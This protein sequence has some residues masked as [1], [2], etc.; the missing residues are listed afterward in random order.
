VSSSDP[1]LQLICAALVLLAPMGVSLVAPNAG[2]RFRRAAVTAGAFGAGAS[3]ATS[4]LLGTPTDTATRILDAAMASS[5][6]V[7]VALIAMQRLGVAGG[8]VFAVGYGL[9]IGPAITNA[10]LG[11][12]PALLLT[13]FGA[14]DYAGVLATHVAPAAALLLVALMPT[15]AGETLPATVSPSVRR[16]LLGALFVGVG[17]L[18]WLIGLEGAID[19]VTGRIAVN[20]AVG[21]LIAV[22]AWVV[23]ERV[24][25]ARFT[26]AGMVAGAIAGWAAVG[27]GAPF[28]APVALVAVAFLGGLAAGA[29][30]GEHRGTQGRAVGART[31]IAVIVAVLVGGVITSLLGDGF[32][33]AATGTLTLT[34]AQVGAVIVVGLTAAAGALPCWLLAVAARRLDRSRRDAG[35]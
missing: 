35:R 28:L 10:V 26:P 12:Y 34:A 20:G 7:V 33:L 23:M 27:V 31:V 16:A 25:W 18:A 19:E 22:I 11:E 21:I 24:R 6:S 17:G 3:F 30:P 1:L 14:I 5:V 8:A 13:V 32:G 15:P 4:A 2:P 9:L 29:V